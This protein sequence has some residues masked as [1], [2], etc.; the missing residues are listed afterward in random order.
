RVVVAFTSPTQGVL[1][2][3]ITGPN[4][5]VAELL[6][7]T[8]TPDVAEELT[9]HVGREMVGRR[10][11]GQWVDGFSLAPAGCRV[12]SATGGRLGPDG[13]VRRSWSAQP[14]DGYYV[15][16]SGTAAARWRMT[17]DGVVRYEDTPNVGTVRWGVPATPTPPPGTGPAVAAEAAQRLRAAMTETALAPAPV[18]TPGAGTLPGSGPGDPPVAVVSAC[19]ADGGCAV[20]AQAGTRAWAEAGTSGLGQDNTWTALGVPGLTAVPLATA[21]GPAD[22]VL[23]L[24]PAAAQ[25]SFLDRKEDVLARRNLSGGSVVVPLRDV[26]PGAVRIAVATAGGDVLATVPLNADQPRVVGFAERWI[27]NW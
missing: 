7:S 19:H 2:T 6:R 1:R 9:P 22:R 18:A 27:Q 25:V 13:T 4:A 24:A 11:G 16:G 14:M 3:A 21:P 17:C 12:W 10:A 26:P 23:V 8:A 20:L 5:P 15:H